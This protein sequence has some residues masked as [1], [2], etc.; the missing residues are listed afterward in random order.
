MK[1]FWSA[2]LQSGESSH[3]GKLKLGSIGSENDFSYSKDLFSPELH[4]CYA[5][6]ANS[7]TSKP[8]KVR[9]LIMASLAGGFAV[10]GALYG[11]GLKQQQETKKVRDSHLHPLF[12]SGTTLFL[13]CIISWR[14]LANLL[15]PYRKLKLVEKPHQRRESP[16]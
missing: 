12:E 2:W 10:T 8:L 13:T 1:K 7:I 3:A 15:Y 16:Y 4:Q 6:M 11:A 9:P 14:I 5:S